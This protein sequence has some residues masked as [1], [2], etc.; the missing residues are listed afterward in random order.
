D[1]TAE[2]LGADLVLMAVG[3]GARLRD[4]GLEA[5][6]VATERGFVKVTSRMETSLPGLYAIGDAAGPPLLAHKASAEGVVAAEAIAGHAPA[7][8]DYGAVPSCTYCHPQVAS[9]G[10]T[11][12]A[13]R[14]RGL[15]VRVGKYPFQANG[16]AQ[17]LAEPEG[18]V[19]IVASAETGEILGV[20]ILGAEATE[21]IAEVGVGRTLEAT[22]EDIALTM[23]AHPTMSEAVLEAALDAMGKA[24]HL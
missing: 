21:L 5:L 7:A 3:R 22:V 23:H 15:G 9:L 11:E 19:K 17:A 6:G 10:L 24:I 16:K 13:A 2:R 4:G 18:L 20:H 1:G 8:I 12:Q 14:E